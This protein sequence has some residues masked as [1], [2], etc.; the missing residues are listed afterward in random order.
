MLISIAR[1]NYSCP[2][3]HCMYEGNAIGFSHPL[4]IILL[5]SFTYQSLYLF[6]SF[7]VSKKESL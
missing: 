3:Y 7:L 5:K 1:V 6:F 2:M 4:T